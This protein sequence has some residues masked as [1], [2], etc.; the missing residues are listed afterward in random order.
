MNKV[1]VDIFAKL[2]QDEIA[3]SALPKHGVDAESVTINAINRA[4]EQNE[5]E[6]SN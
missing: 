1:T 6:T 2:V 5:E 4:K 3:K